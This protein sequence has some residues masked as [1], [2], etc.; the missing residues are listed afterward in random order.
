M[1]YINISK[2]LDNYLS[3]CKCTGGDSNEGIGLAGGGGDSF[4]FE[5]F[6]H[7]YFLFY[8]IHF[9]LFCGC[10]WHRYNTFLLLFSV[11]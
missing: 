6:I 3:R 4:F 8:F 1:Y 11:T 2:V 10:G 9:L 5:I 7:F